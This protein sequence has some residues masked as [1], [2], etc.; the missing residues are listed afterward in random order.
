MTLTLTSTPCKDVSLFPFDRQNCTLVF[1]S[2]TYDARD[3]LFVEPGNIVV[4]AGFT[5]NSE[6]HLDGCPGKL[7]QR[8]TENGALFHEVV[9]TLYLTRLPLFY[10]LNIIIP[11]I[12]M[13][14]LSIGVFYLPVDS[15]EKMTLSRVLNLFSEMFLSSF[16][17]SQRFNYS[18]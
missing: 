17:D 6:W 1:S 18:I 3:L 11:I 14:L 4:D 15:G 12:L 16:T 10:V 13:F 9:F 7:S 2:S 8:Q 5:E